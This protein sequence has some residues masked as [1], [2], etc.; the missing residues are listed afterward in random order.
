MKTLIY[1]VIFGLSGVFGAQA[2]DADA[3][4]MAQ[5]SCK[6]KTVTQRC[7]VTTS[8]QQTAGRCVDAKQYGLICLKN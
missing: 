1:G 2:S 6:S 5:Q 8:S 3:L 4:Q 7:M